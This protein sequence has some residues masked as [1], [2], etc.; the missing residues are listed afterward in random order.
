[1]YGFAIEM[2]AVATSSPELVDVQDGGKAALVVVYGNQ[3]VLV[4]HEQTEAGLLE[5]AV[6]LL[7]PCC[8]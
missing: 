4:K 7:L 1:M 5:H 3:S 6:F 8:N 2:T